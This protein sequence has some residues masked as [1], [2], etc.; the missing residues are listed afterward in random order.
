[1]FLREDTQVK[2]TNKRKEKQICIK[3]KASLIH[4]FILSFSFIEFSFNAKSFV[5]VI[6]VLFFS[7]F[8][9]FPFLDGLPKA[10]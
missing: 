6:L 2:R 5:I 4:L 1:M 7:F 10:F 9:S 3:S 8:P